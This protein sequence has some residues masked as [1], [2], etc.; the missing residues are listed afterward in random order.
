MKSQKYLMS[1]NPKPDNYLA[2][3]G[4]T[5]CITFKFLLYTSHST[6]YYQLNLLHQNIQQ[7]L[8]LTVMNTTTLCQ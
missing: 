3:K 2:V 8:Q 4:L 7:I 5:F 6:F 1:G